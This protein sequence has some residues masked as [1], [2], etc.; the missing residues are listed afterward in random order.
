[1]TLPIGGRSGEAFSAMKMRPWFSVEWR[2]RAP[3]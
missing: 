3:M 1:M 2:P